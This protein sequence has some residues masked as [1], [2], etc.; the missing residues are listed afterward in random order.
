MGDCSNFD[1]FN[2]TFKNRNRCPNC[3]KRNI[4]T[5]ATCGLE[6]DDNKKRM[7]KDCAY[8][9]RREMQKVTEAL[10]RKSKRLNNTPTVV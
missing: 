7:C 6:L 4:S 9:Q 2:M 10:Y 3:K 8:F 5:C 1:C